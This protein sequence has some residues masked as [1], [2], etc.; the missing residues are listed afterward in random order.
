MTVE[1][2]TILQ[3]SLHTLEEYAG[4]VLDE[5]ESRDVNIAD[6]R[7]ALENDSEGEYLSEVIDEA[8]DRI[9]GAGYAYTEE[10]DSLLI[11]PKGIDPEDNS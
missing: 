4:M 3:P 7:K 9:S 6:L 8:L 5:A 2:E 11:Y 1:A 10:D